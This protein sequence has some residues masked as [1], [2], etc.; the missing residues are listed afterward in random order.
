[1][2]SIRN[3]SRSFGATKAVDHVSLEVPR[4]E[5][6]CLVGP[7]GC[8]KSTLLRMAAGLTSSDSGAILIEGSDVT[9]IPANRR[10]TA[11]VFQSHALWPHMTV[12]RN[13]G[14]GLRV[15]KVPADEQKR[16]I[17]AVLDLVGLAGFE[18]RYPAEMSGGQ[19]QRVALARCLVVEPRILLM[20]EPFSAL[21]AHLRQKLRDDLKALQRRLG[22]TT[23]FVTHDQEEA[24]EIADRIAVMR[25]GKIEQA[26]RLGGQC[27]V[28]L[29]N[30]QWR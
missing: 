25:S 11:M 26:D 1:M 8:G 16:R 27:Q 7:S 9:A 4:G 28:N 23:L 3:L 10:P 21:D 19:A 2:L 17:A 5:L 24:M 18:K 12:E 22:L 13:I 20:D 30:T 15:R 14:F 29:P 6:L